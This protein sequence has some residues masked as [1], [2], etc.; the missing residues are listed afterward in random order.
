MATPVCPVITRS[1]ARAM[2]G[3]NAAIPP[4]QLGLGGRGG[5]EVEPDE[6]ERDE[7]DQTK[8]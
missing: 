1:I 2:H 5:G 6:R 7:Q 3:L 8:A 4:A